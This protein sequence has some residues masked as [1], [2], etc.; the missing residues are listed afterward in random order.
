MAQTNISRIADMIVPEVMADMIS[1]KVEE[2]VI[3]SKIAKVD[4]TLQGTAGNEVTVPQYKYIGDAEDIAEGVAM[5]TAKLETGSTSFT[6]KKA[7]KGV[8]ITDEAVLSGYGDP[9][10]EAQKQLAMSIAN[11]IEKDVVAVITTPSESVGDGKV[12]LIYG[13]GSTQISY[14]GVVDAEDMFDEEVSSDKVLYVH[15]K[16]M[17][18][19][20]K[21]T[22]FISADKYDGK[23]MTSGEVGKIGTCRVVRSKK[24]PCIEYTKDNTSG[25]IEIVADSVTENTTKKH[26]ATIQPVTLEKLAVGDKVTALANPYYLNPMVKL[27]NDSET[28]AD[29]PAVTIY[30]KR[31]TQVEKERHADSGTTDIYTN[32]HYGVALTNTTKVVIAKFKK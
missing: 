23:V 17:T 4:T 12:Q 32:K 2:K 16:Q 24:I 26:L 3:V 8:A 9:V 22:D 7:G 29:A 25:T 30:L 19:L 13:N 1:A 11:K 15:P 5:G 14:A 21:D 28:E 18:K 10:G 20:R 31:D 27:T 6:I